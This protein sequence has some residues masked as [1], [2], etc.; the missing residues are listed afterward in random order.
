MAVHQP[1]RSARYKL[2]SQV[3]GRAFFRRAE[4]LVDALARSAAPVELPIGI[5]T[6]L[7]GGPILLFFLRAGK[8][9]QRED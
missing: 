5:F 2:R 1:C 7:V 8:L 6:T 4:V 9:R 3:L